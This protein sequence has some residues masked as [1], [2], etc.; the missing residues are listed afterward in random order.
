M[1]IYIHLLALFYLCIIHTETICASNMNHFSGCSCVLMCS[2]MSE[3][4][5]ANGGTLLGYDFVN[6]PSCAL[7]NCDDGCRCEAGKALDMDGQCKEP[8]SC[9]YLHDDIMYEKGPVDIGDP[10][11]EWSVFFLLFNYSISP[12]RLYF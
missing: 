12:Y 1:C 6:P 2:D 3:L 9:S 10:C 7:E 8:S 4:S 11:Q 5:A